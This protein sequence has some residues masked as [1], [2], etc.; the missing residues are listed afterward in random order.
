M[1]S[2]SANQKPVFEESDQSESDKSLE[3][4]LFFSKS[5]SYDGNTR[6]TERR[7]FMES[8]IVP[9]REWKAQEKFGDKS[10]ISKLLGRFGRFEDGAAWIS[11]A[12]DAQGKRFVKRMG[13]EQGYQEDSS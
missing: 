1:R 5:V 8:S 6:I 2:A 12:V 3:S 13:D 7:A 10:K 11:R 9:D 4:I